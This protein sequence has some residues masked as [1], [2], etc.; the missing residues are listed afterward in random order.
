MVIGYGEVGKLVVKYALS[1]DITS[2]ILVVRNVESI[3][4]LIDNRVKV[5]NYDEGREN[6]DNS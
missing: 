3:T 2:L 5:M 6:T 1:H 4:D